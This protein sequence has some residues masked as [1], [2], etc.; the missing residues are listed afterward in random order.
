[1]PTL[2]GLTT[3]R[4]STCKP[5]ER[6]VRVPAHHRA[7]VLPQVGEG[8]LPAR[9]VGVD[10]QDLLVVAGGA[11]GEQHPPEA[12]DR[13]R[14]RVRQPLE[15]LDVRR[16]E[17]V[18]PP[19]STPG[20]PA[21][22]RLPGPGR[23]AAAVGVA[24]HHHRPLAEG[25]HP[26]E[27][28]HRLRAGRVVA[29]EDDEVGVAHLGLS[30]DGV[31]RGQHPVDVREHRDGVQHPRSLTPCRR[32]RSTFGG[33][34]ALRPRRPR[35]PSDGRAGRPPAPPSVALVQSGRPAPCCA[36][37]AAHAQERESSHGVPRR[38]ARSCG[39]RGCAAWG[40][41]TG[42]R[43]GVGPAPL[44]AATQSGR[45]LLAA[46][47][48]AQAH[49]RGAPSSPGSPVGRGPGCPSSGR[50]A[51]PDPSTAWRFG[52]TGPSGALSRERDTLA[53]TTAK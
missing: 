27:H 47:E 35:P 38:P 23:R 22:G 5:Q 1:M 14:H 50:G 8:L 51:A 41:S 10:E 33:S 53:M 6:H 49:R 13:Q 9:H 37:E 18:W 17:A 45:G 44:R 3:T 21:R 29:R 40:C 19:R 4:R 31:E 39:G 2:P 24:P 26:V 46:E 20:R 48:V 15:Q 30:Q 52:V 11:V 32:R 36:Q 34:S 25:Q 12:A 16:R 42:A 28:L 43:G 7:D